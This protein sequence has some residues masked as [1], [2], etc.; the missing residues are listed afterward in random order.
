MPDYSYVDAIKAEQIRWL[1]KTKQS[2]NERLVRQGIRIGHMMED[3]DTK[4]SQER[5]DRLDA[6]YA[7]LDGR[8]KAAQVAQYDIEPSPL[9][10][11]DKVKAHKQEKWL[12]A[13][14]HTDE[15]IAIKTLPDL[16]GKS[17]YVP[18]YKAYV[19]A[20]QAYESKIST[21]SRGIQ[22]EVQRN[23]M[24]QEVKNKIPCIYPIKGWND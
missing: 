22:S 16:D 3:K 2:R 15:T 18:E 24:T 20:Y 17:D 6:Y 23:A 1:N 19:A 4:Y 12:D 8:R 14:L 13:Y 21:P 9:S 5:L 10:P 7:D 11:Y